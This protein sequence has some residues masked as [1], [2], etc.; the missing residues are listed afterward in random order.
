M[1]TQNRTAYL[2][3]LGI[4][5]AIGCGG[6]R[7][8]P[9]TTSTTNS[10]EAGRVTNMHQHFHDVGE[11]QLA[12]ISGNLVSTRELAKQV[13]AGFQGPQP[14]GWAPFIE[15]SVASAEMLEVTDDLNMAARLAATLA[16]TCGDCHR[17]HEL[18]VVE[19]VAAPPPREEDR[20]SDFMV[21][22]RWA[23]DRMWE[24]LIAPSDEAW[25]A[26]ASVLATTELTPED[27]GE[28]LVLTPEIET[29]LRQIRSDASSAGS[30][31]SAEERQEL[32]GSFLAGCASCH[33]DMMNQRD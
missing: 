14:Q 23:A 7:S 21:Q 25:L 10:E 8:K 5:A 16:N 2:A 27:V 22:H 24:G 31:T 20:F 26:G 19:H 1:S 28:R 15:R 30:A 13:R 3:A 32:Y 17:A 12:L 6:G 11:I 29:I 18:T 4:L 9:V 33:R